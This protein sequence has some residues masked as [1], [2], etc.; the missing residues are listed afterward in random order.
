VT[1]A[2]AG[3]FAD[4]PALEF[5]GRRATYRQLHALANRAAKGFQQLG[6]RP[7][8]HVGLF[9]ADRVV[10]NLGSRA[11]IPDIPGLVAAAPL[12]NV[13]AL[14]LD[15]VPDRLIVIGSDGM[16]KAVQQARQTHQ[17]IG[18]LA[19]LLRGCRR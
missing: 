9:A 14:E 6:V 13:E 5:M 12:T 4:R 10:L 18:S 2:R 3:P 16:M 11:A 8:V 7:G 15:R 17:V 1:K 19:V